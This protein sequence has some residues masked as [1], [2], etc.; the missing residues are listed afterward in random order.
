MLGLTT[1][2]EKAGP[3]TVNITRLEESEGLRAAAQALGGMEGREVRDR[4]G[5]GRVETA[6]GDSL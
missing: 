2:W 3:L 1:Q 6:G 4:E 5:V